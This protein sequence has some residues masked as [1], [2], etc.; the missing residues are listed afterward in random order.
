VQIGMLPGDARPVALAP[1]IA[2]EVA[3]L[4]SFRFAGELDD[5]I[6][7]LARDDAL[8]AVVSHVL[9]LSDAAAAFALAADP[10]ASSKVVLALAED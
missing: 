8:E 4:G 10:A 7:L 1:L 5:A 3:L 6:A 9:P 2:K